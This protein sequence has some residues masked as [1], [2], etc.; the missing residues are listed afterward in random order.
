MG[1]FNINLSTR[2]FSAYRLTNLLLAGLL[3]LLIGIT[4]W[5]GYWFAR[6]AELAGDIRDGENNIRVESEALDRRLTELDAQLNTPQASSKLSEIEYLNGLIIRKSFSWTQVFSSLEN[7]VPDSVRLTNLQPEI[8]DNGRTLMHIGV[9][10]RNIGAI[11]DFITAL[12][13]SPRFENVIVS[14]EEKRDP[15]VPDDVD[16]A[17]TVGYFPERGSQ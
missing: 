1:E 17:L 5:Q 3:V 12:E 2:P 16:V 4:L 15:A 8:L 11:S 6:Y 10:G 13:E 7:L 14:V 9:R